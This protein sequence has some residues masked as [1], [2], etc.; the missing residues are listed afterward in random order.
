ML[1][2]TTYNG[3]IGYVLGSLPSHRLALFVSVLDTRLSLRRFCLRPLS[4]EE[5]E[6]A[7]E[8]SWPPECHNEIAAQKEAFTAEMWS[9]T[10]A[11]VLDQDISQAVGCVLNGNG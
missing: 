2:E 1:S 11:A 10:D 9:Q 5:F 7:F 3:K 8:W 6:Y 4:I